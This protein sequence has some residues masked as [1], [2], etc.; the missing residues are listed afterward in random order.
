MRLRGVLSSQIDFL[1]NR[2]S[3]DPDGKGRNCHI[4]I[5]L[6]SLSGPRPAA[7]LLRSYVE[8]K[9]PPGAKRRAVNLHGAS[10]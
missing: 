4:P 3:V 7:V 10:V 8:H 1:S 5:F 2:A 9:E 6:L